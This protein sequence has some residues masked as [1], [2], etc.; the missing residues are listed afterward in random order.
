MFTRARREERGQGLVEYALII[1]LVGLAAIVALGFLSGK[2]NGLFSKA[3]NS[4][5]NVPV[6]SG[7]TVTPPPPPPGNGTVNITCA[8]GIPGVCDGGSGT[9]VTASLTGFAGA[10]SFTF[11]WERNVTPTATCNDPDGIGIFGP[12]NWQAVGST[13]TVNNP[14]VDLLSDPY[15]VAVTASNGGGSVGPVSDCENIFPP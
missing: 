12:P 9:S 8:G 4:L 13:Q 11:V 10:T 2:I 1:A 14:P 5:N 7:G 15:R 6:A 3:G